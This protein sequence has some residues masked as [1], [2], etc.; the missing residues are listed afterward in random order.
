MQGKDAR[1]S[2]SVALEHPFFQGA[3]APPS[4]SAADAAALQAFAC[5]RDMLDQLCEEVAV[6]G[7]RLQEEADGAKWQQIKDACD[8][9]GQEEEGGSA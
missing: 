3:A 6:Q 9:V 8:G 1:V 4:P 2:A 5:A 7:Q